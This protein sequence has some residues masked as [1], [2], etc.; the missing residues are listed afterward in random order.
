MKASLTNLICQEI[1]SVEK[2]R[3]NARN[4]LEKLENYIEIAYHDSKWDAEVTDRAIVKRDNLRKTFEKLCH[5]R[6]ALEDFRTLLVAKG[7]I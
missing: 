5:K 2:L 7:L 4:E 1:E 6:E 3:V